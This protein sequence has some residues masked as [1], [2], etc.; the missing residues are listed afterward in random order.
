VSEAK[1]TAKKSFDLQSQR[2]GLV[3]MTREWLSVL[4]KSDEAKGM[5]PSELVKQALQDVVSGRITSEDIEKA[6]EKQAAA[7]EATEKKSA[8]EEEKPAKDEKGKK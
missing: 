3:A 2:Y 6:R 1:E 7:T 5:G 8:A 4:K